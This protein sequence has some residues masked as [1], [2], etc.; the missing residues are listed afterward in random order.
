MAPPPKALSTISLFFISIVCL[1]LFIHLFSVLNSTYIWN[2]T[3]FVFL[4][5]ISLRKIPSRFIYVI[6]NGKIFIFNCWIIFHFIYVYTY[7]FLL[8]SFIYL[9]IPRL[10]PYHGY[11]FINKAAINIG[12]HISVQ[13]SGGFFLWIS[14]QSG[15]AGSLVIVLPQL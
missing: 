9:W 14:C 3:T 11:G 5:L 2:D 15:I 7:V 8:Y 12:V 10:F 1:G 13:I 6:A 4:W